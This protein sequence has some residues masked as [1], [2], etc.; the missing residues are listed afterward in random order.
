MTTINIDRVQA[1]EVTDEVAFN[2][3]LGLKGRWYGPIP[4]DGDKP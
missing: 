4:P 3:N 2:K 1:Y